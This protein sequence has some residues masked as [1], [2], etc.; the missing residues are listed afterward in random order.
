MPS[1]PKEKLFSFDELARRLE[2]I[3]TITSDGKA[4]FEGFEVGELETVLITALDWDD[5]IPPSERPGLVFKAI[6]NAGI[7]GKITKETLLRELALLEKQVRLAPAREYIIASTISMKYGQHLRPKT[8]NNV[9]FSFHEKL[10]RN[11][12]RKGIEW[13]IDGDRGAS[14]FVGHGFAQQ[15]PSFAQAGKLDIYDFEFVHP[16][17]RIISP[18]AVNLRTGNFGCWKRPRRCRSCV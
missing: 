9:R 6:S 18:S 13:N 7:K 5:Q 1:K 2:K 3:K 15:K 12:D 16:L 14:C 10:P 11:I 17:C 4:S 8:L